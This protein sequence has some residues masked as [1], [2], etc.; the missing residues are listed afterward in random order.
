MRAFGYTT[1][2]ATLL[3]VIIFSIFASQPYCGTAPKV[4]SRVDK[5]TGNTYELIRFATLTR[6]EFNESRASLF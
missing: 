2:L 1:V 5:R 4:Y 6:V 3:T